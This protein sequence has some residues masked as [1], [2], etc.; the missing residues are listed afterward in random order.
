MKSYGEHSNYTHKNY[1]RGAGRTRDKSVEF[2][3]APHCEICGRNIPRKRYVSGVIQSVK[4]WKR[5]KTCGKVFSKKE[6][7]YIPSKC[8]KKWKSIPENNG[9]YLGLMHR[10]C[11]YCGKDHLSYVSRLQGE[12]LPEA[13]KVCSDKHHIANNKKETPVYHCFRCGG[14]IV[15][16]YKGKFRYPKN[17]KVFCS[18][19]C[20][21][22]TRDIKRI[23]IACVVCGKKMS[24][25]P[26]M[27]RTRKSCSL[28]CNGKIKTLKNNIL[29]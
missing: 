18:K 15:G 25:I 4:Y 8:L 20:A 3:D 28:S 26:S 16:R 29:V 2:I 12:K 27:A 7:K 24:L 11:K 1:T 17:G 9:R 14:K 19:S 6:N 5:M 21:N 10:K 13:C 22:K 23:E